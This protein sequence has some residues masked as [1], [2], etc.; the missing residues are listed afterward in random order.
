[1]RTCSVASRFLDSPVH[2]DVLELS[3]GQRRLAACRGP[4]RTTTRSTC[5]VS[6]SFRRAAPYCPMAF[7]GF[8]AEQI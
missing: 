6:S 1:M 5:N 4:L 3:P 2:R 7:F 8:L